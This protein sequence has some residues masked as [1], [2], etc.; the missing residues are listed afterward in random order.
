[1]SGGYP[2]RAACAP[3]HAPSPRPQSLRRPPAPFTPL[4]STDP[5]LLQKGAAAESRTARFCNLQALYL[6]FAA[7]P[8]A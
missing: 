1:M 6:T 8:Q 5:V 7:P 2:G 4:S 3:D